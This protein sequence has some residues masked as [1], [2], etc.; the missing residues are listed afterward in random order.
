MYT[1]TEIEAAMS[2]LTISRILALLMFINEAFVVI[3]TPPEERERV[4]LPPL[5][6]LVF[7]LLILPFFF[8]LKLPDWL[9]AIAIFLQAVGLFIEVFSEI[10][11]SRAQSFSVVSDKG[12]QPQ[13][14][15][16]YRW[17]EHPIYVGIVLQMLGWSFFLPIVMISV[18]LNYT[19]LRKMVNNERNYLSSTLNFSHRGLD[20]PLWN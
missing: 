5:P 9:A 15:G 14:T 10:Q 19:V 2:L 16:F 8:A 12:T 11:L 6:A 3:R 17:F 4:I 13:I 1:A 7:S 20:T 18:Y